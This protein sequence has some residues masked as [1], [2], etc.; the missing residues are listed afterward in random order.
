[1]KVALT[2]VTVSM[3]LAAC[4]HAEVVR[5]QPTNAGVHQHFIGGPPTKAEVETDTRILQHIVGT[6]TTADDPQWATYNVLIIQPDGRFRTI[7]T[8][9]TKRNCDGA[10]FVERGVLILVKTNA[11]PGNYYGF[12]VIDTLD[13]HQLVCGVDVS[14]AGRLRFTK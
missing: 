7:N 9:G 1:M 3:L 8:N 14:A 13:D 2:L 6:W 10:W 5:Q 12:H 4:R 11:A